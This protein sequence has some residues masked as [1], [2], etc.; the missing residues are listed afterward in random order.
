[1]STSVKPPS[2][3]KPTLHDSLT[4]ITTTADHILTLP[5]TQSRFTPVDRS[6]ID[7]IKHCV[8]LLET[9]WE[10]V[11][12]DDK[13]GD[14]AKPA[15]N[16]H[17]NEMKRDLKN[18]KK[19]SELDKLNKLSM[20]LTMSVSLLASTWEV[21]GVDE[22]VEEDEV[23]ENERVKE[24]DSDSEIEKQEPAKDE[25]WVD[26]SKY[27]KYSLLD[28]EFKIEEIEREEKEKEQEKDKFLPPL[29]PVR[30][31]EILGNISYVAFY[32][33]DNFT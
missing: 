5:P 10:Y 24:D 28:T 25:E 6:L 3:E 19:R 14:D 22:D 8:V 2:S 32:P 33:A 11:L 29:S 27:E 20:E 12:A 15:A 31:D 17:K 23:K 9:R 4:T 26:V 1:M 13:N 18:L 30:K 21:E 7:A 16:E